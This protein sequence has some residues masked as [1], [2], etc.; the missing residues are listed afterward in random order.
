[1]SHKS[2]RICFFILSA[3]VVFWVNSAQAA[4]HLLLSTKIF[5]T[6][7]VSFI[8]HQG[9]GPFD[10]TLAMNI[11]YEPVKKIRQSLSQK[12]G[13]QLNF[14]KLW[15]PE[16]E[17]HVTVITPVEYDQMIKP[18]LSMESIEQIA[19]KLQIQKSDFKILGLGRGQAVVNSVP[20]E[21]Y[22]IIVRSLNLLN[23][24]NQI[25]QEYLN[26]GGP[27]VAWDPNHFYPHI[28]VGFS[29]TD[30]HE[31]QGVLKDVKHSLDRRFRIDLVQHKNIFLNSE[32]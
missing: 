9:E 18:Y 29:L 15:N 13:Y 5:K 12:L 22:F 17:A 24:R 8:S 26:H 7:E 6:T 23:I 3:F 2:K 25:Y 20:Q 11:P 31:N 10:S 19:Q 14:F 27:A 21:T 28:T 16:G 1:M 30:L 4:S 32:N